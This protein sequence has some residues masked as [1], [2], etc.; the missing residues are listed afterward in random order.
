MRNGLFI[1]MVLIG[2]AIGSLLGRAVRPQLFAPAESRE[3]SERL[4]KL[5][6]RPLEPGLPP[7]SAGSDTV[8]R[9]R[10]EVKPEEATLK[11]PGKGAEPQLGW[12]PATVSALELLKGSGYAPVR[13]QSL[14]IKNN[15]SQYQPTLEADLLPYEQELLHETK[16]HASAMR[17]AQREPWVEAKFQVIA[18]LRGPLLTIVGADWLPWASPSA[19]ASYYSKAQRL[20]AD[21]MAELEQRLQRYEVARQALIVR[22]VALL[23]R[24]AQEGVGQLTADAL[25]VRGYRPLLVGR[26]DSQRLDAAY[27][28]YEKRRSEIT[29]RLRADLDRLEVR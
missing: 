25:V 29:S 11:P 27:E 9:P 1:L 15:W 19:S 28:Q 14:L 12:Q 21:A 16:D 22:A 23:Q 4:P 5:R 7:S 18:A 10:V 3:A 13:H 6:E 2:V 20:D 26:E 17:L 24:A 8:P